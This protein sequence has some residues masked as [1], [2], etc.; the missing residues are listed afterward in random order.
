LN[1]MLQL[2][3]GLVAEHAREQRAGGGLVASGPGEMFVEPAE[4]GGQSE[5]SQG[6]RFQ[7]NA[8]QTAYA[9]S[10]RRRSRRRS[11]SNKPW[12]RKWYVVA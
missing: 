1:A 9:T 5:D 4:R 3:G 10:S 12:F 7:A 6:V 8:R 2:V 11:S